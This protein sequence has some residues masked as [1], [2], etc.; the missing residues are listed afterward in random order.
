MVTSSSFTIKL[1]KS[2][3]TQLPLEQKKLGELIPDTQTSSKENLFSHTT[4]HKKLK[5]SAP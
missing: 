3:T 4:Y 1:K 2:K 5:L